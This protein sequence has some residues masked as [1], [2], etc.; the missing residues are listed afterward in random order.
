MDAVF[1]TNMNGKLKCITE[2]Q[3]L[4]LL[5]IIVVDEEKNTKKLPQFQIDCI[6]YACVC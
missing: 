1:L 2:K 6:I 5:N 4:L 3:R